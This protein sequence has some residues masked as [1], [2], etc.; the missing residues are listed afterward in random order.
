[1]KFIYTGKNKVVS[2]EIKERV[3]KKVGKL[4]KFFH[5]E[6]E[7][8][9][10]LSFQRSLQKVEVTIPFNG[11]VF[12]AESADIDIFT[13]IDKTVDILERQIRKNKTRLE[14]RLREGSFH[15][16]DLSSE[17][18]DEEPAYQIIKNKRF[19]IKPM[20]LQEA[21]LQM[22]ML[23]HKFFVFANE[24]NKINVVYKRDDGNYGVIQ[25]EG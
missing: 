10:V 21:I 12:R 5:E 11:V 1:M 24:H 16:S 20:D 13:S 6:T 17:I 2:E 3:S 15:Y 4:Q 7:V 19:D 22:N 8:F 23:G 9:V 25:P 14:K 18:I